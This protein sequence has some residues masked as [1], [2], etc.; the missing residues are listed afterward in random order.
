MFSFHC[1][2]RALQFAP[3]FSDAASS[4]CRVLPPQTAG[5]SRA[6]V[7]D[8]LRCFMV[9][10]VLLL[11]VLAGC[12]TASTHSDAPASA[13]DAI[14]EYP[15]ADEI[16]PGE[17]RLHKIRD[18]VWAHVATQEMGGIVYPSN[19]LVVLDGNGLFLV[20]TA[21]GGENTAALLSAIE[22]H[23]GLP[24]RRSVSTHFHDDR[25][26]G[27]DVL[28]AADVETYATPLTRRLAEAEGNEVPDFILDGL[29][30]AGTAVQFGPVEVFFP[31]VGHTPDNLVIYVPEARVLLG[32]CAVFESSR[33]LPGYLGDADVA[34]WP[35]SLR[36]VRARYPD[37]E[38]LLP[39][40]GV[41][42]GLELL[43]HTI[44]V[45]GSHSERR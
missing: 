45:I 44:T 3:L 42:G 18:G 19:G 8:R 36:R 32:G 26:E 10:I 35:K 7:P 11:S 39:G 40:H 20:D 23:I 15:T 37:A 41:P 38:I 14:A 29:A 1:T 25:V 33:Q 9:C 13:L 24:V 27:V 30:E 21:W 16:P 17:V 2:Y 6:A 31:G 5:H 28:R 43:D 4:L 12:A 22:T 34:A